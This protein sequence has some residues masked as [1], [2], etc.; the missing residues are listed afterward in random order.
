MVKFGLIYGFRNF[1]G[2]LYWVRYRDYIVWR[3]NNMKNVKM[4]N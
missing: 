1:K 2:A 3:M 4:E